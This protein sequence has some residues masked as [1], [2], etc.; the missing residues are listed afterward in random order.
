M[1]YQFVST[2]FGFYSFIKFFEFGNWVISQKIVLYYAIPD[3]DIQAE[4]LAQEIELE[5]V[6]GFVMISKYYYIQKQAK[7]VLFF[8]HDNII[9]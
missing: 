1:L 7:R 5:N 6:A 2:C 3:I 4:L 8:Q 9:W